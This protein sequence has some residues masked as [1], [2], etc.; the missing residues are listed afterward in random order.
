MHLLSSTIELV[1]KVL[2]HKIKVLIQEV[3]SVNGKH[4]L[5]RELRMTTSSILNLPR[6]RLLKKLDRKLPNL[7][8]LHHI[9]ISQRHQTI[10]ASVKNHLLRQIRPLQQLKMSHLNPLQVARAFQV[11]LSSLRDHQVD[12]LQIAQKQQLTPPLTTSAST[13]TLIRRKTTS[14]I[15]LALHLMLHQNQHSHNPL[16]T[17]SAPSL[18]S[19]PRRVILSVSHLNDRVIPLETISRKTTHMMNLKR[20]LL[21]HPNLMS[22]RRIRQVWRLA[23]S[24]KSKFQMS[25]LTRQTIWESMMHTQMKK[26]T[27][28]YEK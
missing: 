22:P 20:S 14:F 9:L 7:E 19:A 18:P 11:N 4:Q 26:M 23:N 17:S 3:K 27:T 16:P 5:L 10:L 12:P 28:S 8:D 15:L 24:Q 25:R 13:L 1:K 21:V 6:K 2:A